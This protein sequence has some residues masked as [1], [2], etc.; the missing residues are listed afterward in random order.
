MMRDYNPEEL[1]TAE[2]F[3]KYV[4]DGWNYWEE[5]IGEHEAQYRSECAMFGDAGPGQ[6]YY[7]NQMNQ[8]MAQ[9]KA[10][11]IQLTG[12]HPSQHAR[13]ISFDDDDC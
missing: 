10:R 13:N 12:C 9:I 2:Q 6:G 11:Y 3:C 8:E 1:M 5:N 7:L 4:R